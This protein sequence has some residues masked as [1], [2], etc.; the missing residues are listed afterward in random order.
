MSLSQWTKYSDSSL[1]VFALMKW[2]QFSYTI[3]G[4]IIMQYNP[5]KKGEPT[6][7]PIVFFLFIFL[8]VALF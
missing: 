8:Q 4:D 3:T 2:L 5:Y 6:P 7:P 1:R